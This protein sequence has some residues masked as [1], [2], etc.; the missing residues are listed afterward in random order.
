MRRAVSDLKDLSIAG[1][2]GDIGSL[3][4]VEFDDA[5]WTVRYLAIDTGTWLPG[6][7]VLVSPMS[8]QAVDVSGGRL[9]VN[10]TKAQIE[11]C[12][13]VDADKPVDR[14]YEVEYSKYYGCLYCWTGPYRWGATDYAGETL[15]G[16]AAPL[17]VIEPPPPMPIEEPGDAH[18]RSASDVTG[19]YIEATD[20]DI[21]HVQDFLVDDRAWAIRYLIVDTRNWLPGKQMIISPEWVSRVSW[22]D[23]RVYV[24][25]TRASVKAA[26]EY[27]SARPLEREHESRLYGHYK[28]P[29]YWR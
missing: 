9:V 13:S 26:P 16:V 21:G 18:L 17:P 10:L 23:S 4:D 7:R 12:P 6:R 27:E 1:T 14:Q 11:A 19:Y 28:R 15:I 29:Q 5:S 24:D 3:Q 2:D 22:S 25:L 20:G 8:V